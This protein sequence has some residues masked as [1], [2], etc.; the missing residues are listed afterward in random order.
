MIAL[1]RERGA[2]QEILGPVS[3]GL[4]AVERLLHSLVAGPG[5]SEWLGA[6]A[7]ALLDAG[8]KRL[9][10][11]LVLLSAHAGEYEAETAVPGAAALE[12]LHLASLVHDDVIDQGTL[13]R[14]FPTVNARW[15]DALAILAGDHLFGKA[16]LAVSKLPGVAARE[17]ATVIGELVTGEVDQ[18][19]G[20]E[21]VPDLDAYLDRIGRKT[22][23]L[24]SAC[25]RMGARLGRVGEVQTARL[26][27]YGWW[28]GLS[29]QVVDDLLDLRGDPAALGKPVG[30]DA[31]AGVVTLPGILLARG[32]AVTAE[33][34]LQEAGAMAEGFAVQARSEVAGMSPTWL[35]RTLEDLAAFVVERTC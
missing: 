6:T 25:C 3:E 34:A 30:M 23:A 29:Y 9:R 1:E 27:Q 2:L 28:L 11:A 35:R 21:R 7:S 32:G 26:T 15:G 18:Q 5:E 13:R 16:V 19:L 31:A 8:G 24:F 14:G 20:R 33:T 10:P 17:L 4:A 22:A 12:L